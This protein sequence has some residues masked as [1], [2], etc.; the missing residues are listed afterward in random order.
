MMQPTEA[1][2]LRAN[3]INR[4]FRVVGVLVLLVIVETVFVFL[5]LRLLQEESMLGGPPCPY[6]ITRP[7]V[8]DG[9]TTS[10]YGR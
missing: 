10:C 9:G 2:F 1:L 8:A 7:Q 3:D 6:S 4:I 5:I